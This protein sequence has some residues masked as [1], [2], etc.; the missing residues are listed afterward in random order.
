MFPLVL[1]AENVTDLFSAP[2]RIK[3]DPK[4]IR[5]TNVAPGTLLTGDGQK[6]NFSEN[7]LN[8]IGEAVITLNRMPGSSAVSGSG[9]LLNLTFQAV[10]PGTSSVTV[11][12]PDLKNLQLQTITVSAPTAM[13]TVQ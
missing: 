7:T 4:V 6:V 9:A 11:L 5:L 10:A 8:D 12:N 3:F 1:R 2:L 13:V